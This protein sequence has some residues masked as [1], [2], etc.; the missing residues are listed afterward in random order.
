LLA[1]FLAAMVRTITSRPTPVAVDEVL[2]GAG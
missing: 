1:I 2:A